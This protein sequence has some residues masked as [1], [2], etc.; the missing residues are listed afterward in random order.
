VKNIRYSGEYSSLLTALV[1]IF[2]LSYILFKVD[3]WIL[4][5]LIIFNLIY[6]ILNQ[7]QVQGTSVRISPHQ[8][9]SI[10]NLIVQASKELNIQVPNSYV[11]YDP[12]INAYVMGFVKPFMLVLTSSMVESMTETELMFV[13]AHELGH[14]KMNHSTLKSFVYPLDRNIPILTFLFNSWLIKTE[15]TA[16]RCGSFVSKDLKS[17]IHALLK[18]AIG[19]NLYSKINSVEIIKQLE[20]TPD[21]EVERVS[22]LFLDHPFITNRIKRLAQYNNQTLNNSL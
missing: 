21:K 10:Y 13:I 15:Y 12:Y 3:L 22:E 16:D 9:F 17:D 18:L 11:Q 6:I 20:E 2:V 7:K 8:F 5:G 1:F 19:N 14:I 4:F